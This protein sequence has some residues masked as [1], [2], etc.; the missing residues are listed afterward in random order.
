MISADYAM[1]YNNG[2][3]TG[4]FCGCVRCRAVRE[5]EVHTHLVALGSMHRPTRRPV[6]NLA[7]LVWSLVTTPIGRK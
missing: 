4:K 6:V 1:A 2:V 7:R 3:L 5:R